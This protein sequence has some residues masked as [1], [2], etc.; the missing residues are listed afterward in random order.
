MKDE[1]RDYDSAGV[2]IGMSLED[3]GVRVRGKLRKKNHSRGGGEGSDEHPERTEE[4]VQVGAAIAPKPSPLH[5]QSEP[6]R[7]P[8]E[9]RGDETE[10]GVEGP[11]GSPV[12][13]E[14][15]G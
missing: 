1:P 2:Y 14:E 10:P 3:F 13:E 6:A 15:G 11:E 8:E 7:R 9:R 5:P 4:P 12:P